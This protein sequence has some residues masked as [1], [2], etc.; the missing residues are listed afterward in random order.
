MYT[1]QPSYGRHFF[2]DNV[3]EKH[4][5]HEERHGVLSSFMTR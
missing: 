3:D 5:T 2:L 4:G 1:N